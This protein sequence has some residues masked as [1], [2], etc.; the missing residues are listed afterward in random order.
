MPSLRIMIFMNQNIAFERN[1]RLVESTGMAGS[2]NR[3]GTLNSWGGEAWSSCLAATLALRGFLD[4]FVHIASQPCPWCGFSGAALQS[5]LG[6]ASELRSQAPWRCGEG[7]GHPEQCGRRR[8]HPYEYTMM[9]NSKN[10]TPYV[11]FEH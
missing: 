3:S 2:H 11:D 1:R 9:N 6:S 8:L 4:M 5:L 7:E 10:E